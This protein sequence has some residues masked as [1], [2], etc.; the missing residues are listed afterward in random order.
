M[1]PRSWK[2]VAALDLKRVGPD[3]DGGYVVAPGAVGN[4]ELLLSMGLND[5][6]RFEEAFQSES[7]ARII[8]YDGSVDRRFWQLYVVKKLLRVRPAQ[9]LHY[10][11]YRKF[12]GS[13]GAEHRKA[14]IGYDGSGSVSLSTVLREIG[15]KRIFLK[16][17]IEGWEYRILDQIVEYRDRFTGVVMELHDVDLHRDRIDRFVGAMTGFTIV[18]LTP[19]NFAGVDSNGDP[20][21]VEI[22]LMRSDYVRMPA[23]PAD[24]VGMPHVRNAADLPDIDIRYE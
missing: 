2:P 17:D 18:H 12:F 6:W 23:H 24:A 19:N 9:A 22:S 1:L 8:C 11:A 20:V 5:D 10:L 3:T 15:S 16:V 14:M 21:V 7:G 4:S 13:G